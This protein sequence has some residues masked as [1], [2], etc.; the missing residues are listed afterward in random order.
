M[1]ISPPLDNSSGEYEILLT[2]NSELIIE[3]I[4][5]TFRLSTVSIVL[6]QVLQ[7]ITGWSQRRMSYLVPYTTT[8]CLS[9]K[10]LEFGASP[11]HILSYD[12]YENR[13]EANNQ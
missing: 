2:S 5:L 3:E 6:R 4:H 1:Q 9:R 8:K 12:V 13:G 7:Q 11:G 10:L